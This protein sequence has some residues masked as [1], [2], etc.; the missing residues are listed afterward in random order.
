MSYDCTGSD[1][2][3][4][5]S[6]SSVLFPVKIRYFGSI[7]AAAG[8]EGEEVYVKAGTSIQALLS[9]IALHHSEEFFGEII[10]SVTREV[11]SDLMVTLNGVILNNTETQM[12]MRML[13]VEDIVSLFPIFPGGG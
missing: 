5:K 4:T 13:Q 12:K 10:D 9:D 6:D 3:S 1:R 11:R 2:V 7:R 8:V